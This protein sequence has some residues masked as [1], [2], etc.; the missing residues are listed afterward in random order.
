MGKVNSYLHVITKCACSC[1]DYV[2]TRPLFALAKIDNCSS[3]VSVACSY[4]H[5]GMMTERSTHAFKGMIVRVNDV[6]GGEMLYK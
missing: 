3:N 1:H 5:Q 4:L 6:T 2:L